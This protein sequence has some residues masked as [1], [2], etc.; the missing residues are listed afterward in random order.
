MCTRRWQNKTEYFAA[1]T[2]NVLGD[3]DQS[4]AWLDKAVGA[5]YSSAEITHTVEFDSLRKDPRFPNIRP[6]R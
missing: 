5:G 6:G 1:K 2:Y 4:L 3:R